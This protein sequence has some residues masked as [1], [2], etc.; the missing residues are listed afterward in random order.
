[1][2]LRGDDGLKRSNRVG[3]D[4]DLKQEEENQVGAD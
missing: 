2:F 1:L 4:N 3:E